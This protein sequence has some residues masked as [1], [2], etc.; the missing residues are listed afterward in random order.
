ME[1]KRTIKASELNAFKKANPTAK[2]YTRCAWGIEE[3]VLYRWDGWLER[4]V[5]G[6]A[7]CVCPGSEIEVKL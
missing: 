7:L 6:M 3:V 2:F 1:N 5:G 4:A